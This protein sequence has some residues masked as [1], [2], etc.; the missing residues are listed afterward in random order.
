MAEIGLK[1]S[2]PELEEE[3]QQK[4]TEAHEPK[5]DP[6]HRYEHGSHLL[7]S[8][9]LYDK[10]LYQ[11]LVT[12]LRPK[13]KLLDAKTVVSSS[14]PGLFS[15]SLSTVYDLI[16]QYDVLYQ[17]FS[18]QHE[19]IIDMEAKILAMLDEDEKKRSDDESKLSVDKIG[20]LKDLRSKVSSE[21][22][23]IKTLGSTDIDTL[24]GKMIEAIV[25][26]SD[27]MKAL[28][29]QVTAQSNGTEPCQ[30]MTMSFDGLAEM[31]GSDKPSKTFTQL[32]KTYD[33][34]LTQTEHSD[35]E[36]KGLA[37]EW[38]K[39]WQT[40]CSKEASSIEPQLNEHFAALN[41]AASAMNIPTNQLTAQ[42][43]ATRGTLSSLE[44]EMEKQGFTTE[45]LKPIIG[46]TPSESSQ[47]KHS[48]LGSLS[49]S[50]NST[51]PDSGAGG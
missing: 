16:Y 47:E 6:A 51:S 14:K 22:E 27:L 28:T 5:Q 39:V 2:P 12:A 45:G 3:A 13:N 7:M 40:Q 19:T 44:A 31:Q 46:G 32:K 37:I 30:N 49:P 1:D 25:P 20:G 4:T 9:C 8:L 36:L 34:L 11:N 50:D 10:T 48:V 33:A 24:K 43:N 17:R 29:E 35:N 18:Y 42:L 38:V 21:K 26:I 41:K 15:K 23:K